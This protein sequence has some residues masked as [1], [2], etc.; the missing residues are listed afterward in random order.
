MH[1]KAKFNSSLGSGSALWESAGGLVFVVEEEAAIEP[2]QHM[3]LTLLR[4][5]LASGR[6]P[7]N[8]ICSPVCTVELLVGAGLSLLE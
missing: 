8:F 1:A 7:E 5:A 4:D 3:F 6:I 2:N